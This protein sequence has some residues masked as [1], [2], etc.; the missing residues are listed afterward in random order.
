MEQPS[1]P[2][3]TNCPFCT[4]Q[5]ERKLLAASELALAFYDKFPVN[6]GHA[7]I[8]PRRHCYDFFELSEEEQS[9]CLKLL[10]QVKQTVQ[11]AFN[12]DGF[13]V[14]VNI[15]LYSGQTVPHAHIH[16]IPRYKG[17]VPEPRGGIRGVI[18]HKQKY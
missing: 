11:A 15:G 14:G 12:P 17:D 8:I 3:D 9:A 5:N 2:V 10:N 7:L 13:N 16:L 18:P 1:Q 4:I 6:P